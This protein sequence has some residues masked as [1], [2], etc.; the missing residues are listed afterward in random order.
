M[1]IPN[2][3]ARTR[4]SKIFGVAG[5]SK[6]AR[7]A[8]QIVIAPFGRFKVVVERSQWMQNIDIVGQRDS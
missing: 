5:N 4:G 3:E 2:G 8:F 1:I 6:T 7:L